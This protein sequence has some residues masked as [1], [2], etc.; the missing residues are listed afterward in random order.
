MALRRISKE[1]VHNITSG[2]VITDLNNIVKELV[3]NSIDAN[4]TSINVTF[5]KLGSEGLEVS[6]NGDGIKV[7]DFPNLCRKNYTSKLENFEK[8]IDVKTL[9]FRGE[10]LNSICNVSQVS[11]L[12]AEASK[13]PRGYDLTFDKEGDLVAQKLINQSKGTTIKI[14]DIFKN[15]P[16]RRLHLEK[17]S[18]KEFQKC[19]QTLMSYLLILTNIRII[20]YNV[21]AS[22]KKK[23][24]MKTAGNSF[25]KDNIIN[26]Y[27]ATG[28]Q[29]L[30][31]IDLKIDLDEKYSIKITGLLSNSS[32]GSGRLSKDRQYLYINQRPVEFKKIMKLVNDVYKKFNYLQYP[33]VLLNLEIH[34]HLIDINVTP[35]KK[36]ILMSNKY[37]MILMN[38]LETYL[39]SH[40]D[41]EG[42]Y[43]IPVNQSYQEKII[44]RNS[45]TTQP[46]LESFALFQES[47]DVRDSLE[48][49]Q[50]EV[51]ESK[52]V[53]N[54][55]VIVDFNYSSASNIEDTVPSVE[56]YSYTGKEVDEGGRDNDVDFDVDQSENEPITKSKDSVSIEPMQCSSHS[57]C[58][59]NDS[60]ELEENTIKG[61]MKSSLDVNQFSPKSSSGSCCDS[62]DSEN[63]NHP[64]YPIISGKEDSEANQERSGYAVE[65]VEE[66][67][68]DPQRKEE[69]QEISYVNQKV[70]V[71]DGSLISKNLKRRRTSEHL[72]LK[73]SLETSDIS[74]RNLSE[75]ILGLSIHKNDFNNMK[76]VGQFNKGFIIVYKR[77]TDDILIIDQH[78]SDEKFNFEKLIDETVFENQPLVVPQKI[79]LNTIERLTILNNLKIFEKNGFKFKTCVVGE[80]G[81]VESEVEAEHF[82]REELY[83]TALP[84]SKNTIFDLKD[85]N[86]LIQLVEEK[87]ASTMSIPRPSK[88]RSMFAMRACRSSIMIGSSLSRLKME[89]VVQNLSALDK[90]WNCPHGRPTMRHLVKIDQWKPFTDDYQLN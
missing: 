72:T 65:H 35:D 83:L 19:L 9:G 29:G 48:D 43:N 38:K 5:K 84:Y 41:N 27:G 6:D 10:A 68:V 17:H 77:D 75:K 67:S 20:V 70:R 14:N 53:Q 23:I 42:S 87:G 62:C 85:L 36:T 2:Q 51:M 39:E 4:S 22:G 26:V 88:V 21:D 82:K 25:L 12:T 49:L 74:N 52:G 78:A 32:I 28:L 71:R 44:E 50:V 66:E 18:R 13:A 61:I 58:A 47:A 73:S 76:I 34:E 8:L 15:L 86:E 45:C 55:Q 30:E 16:V 64:E 1:D 54:S 90:P 46:K 11:I 40:W 24:M 69:N 79:D 3:E 60:V 31:E 37:E 81:E 7:E 80:E 63:L 59:K 89:T 56:M 57:S 33:M